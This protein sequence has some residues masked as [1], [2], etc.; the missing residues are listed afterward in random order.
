VITLKFNKKEVRNPLLRMVFFI[1]LTVSFLI[2]TVAVTVLCPV[3]IPLDILL[4]FSG[5]NGFFRND[6][7]GVKFI[8]DKSSFE[9]KSR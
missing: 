1:F 6:L 5:R 4:Q 7:G 8:M 3:W 2:M 9:R